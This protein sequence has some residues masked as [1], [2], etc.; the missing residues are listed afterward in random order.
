MK[1][2]KLFL[3]MLC[4]FVITGL[5]LPLLAQ[6]NADAILKKAAFSLQRLDSFQDE[7]VVYITGV[8]KIT[9]D[10]ILKINIAFKKPDK[11]KIK[12]INLKK[13]E[14]VLCDDGVNLWSY[15]SD[16]GK[17]KKEKTLE[18]LPLY[19]NISPNLA[20]YFGDSLYLNLLLSKDPYQDLMKYVKSSKVLEENVLYDK[21]VYVLELQQIL[22]GIPPLP[23]KEIPAAVKLWIDKKNYMILKSEYVM[24][25]IDWTG[26]E[27]GR[28]I[29]ME[30]HPSMKI[31]KT[32]NEDMF[33][34]SPPENAKEAEHLIKEIF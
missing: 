20:R 15:I 27:F 34:F 28:T 12:T 4:L 8:P 32:I 26:R 9:D 33:K 11:I 10:T 1:F 5:K 23:D 21:P 30:E 31:N 3:L 19:D 29:I 2:F 22:K 25:A 14:A 17:Y 24:K 6:E 16:M 18:R 7:Y 13:K